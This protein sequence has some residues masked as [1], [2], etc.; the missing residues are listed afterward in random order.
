MFAP[1]R[2]H[3]DLFTRESS[4]SW[5]LT[6]ADG[7]EAPIE[8]EAIGCQLEL[9]DVYE[10]AAREILQPPATSSGLY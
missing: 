1:D 8:L 2:T 3:C 10:E 5:V 9:A 4:G 6:E 7:P